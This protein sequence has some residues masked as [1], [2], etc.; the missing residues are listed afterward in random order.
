MLVGLCGGIWESQMELLEVADECV[1]LQNGSWNSH[2]RRN[3][4]VVV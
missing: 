2:D 4:D 1:G 3:V